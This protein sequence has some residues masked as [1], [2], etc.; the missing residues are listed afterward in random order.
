MTAWQTALD[1]QLQAY[2]FAR[3][4]STDAEVNW[5]LRVR[6][7]DCAHVLQTADTFSWERGP[8]LA[9]R[10]ASASIPLEVTWDEVSDEL[11]AESPALFWWFGGGFGDLV[12]DDLRRGTGLTAL[13]IVRGIDVGGQ[14]YIAIYIGERSGAGGTCLVFLSKLVWL[15][16]TTLGDALARNQQ[17][18]TADGSAMRPEREQIKLIAADHILRFVAAAHVWL[19]QRILIGIDAHI[20][21]HQGKRAALALERPARVSA[22]KVI[23]LRRADSAP[24]SGVGATAVDWACRWI[25]DGHWRRQWH[26]SRQCHELQYIEPY[27]KGPADRPLRLP[28]QTVYRIAR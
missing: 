21:R 27:I 13:L 6:Q 7:E 22:V 26:P 14:K 23:N 25:V 4:V 9:C 8:L 24:S 1:E 20:E 18:V 11:I 3:R 16:S 19:R 2:A 5:P 10:A 15:E 17:V 12:V 28:E